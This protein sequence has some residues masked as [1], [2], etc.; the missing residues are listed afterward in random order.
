MPVFYLSPLQRTPTTPNTCLAR[1]SAH[2]SVYST[3]SYLFLYYS[4]YYTCR[5]CC[6][7]RFAVAL[8]MLG[9]NPLVMLCVWLYNL[10]LWSIRFLLVRLLPPLRTG[11]N[12]RL[13]LL[14][15]PPHH[16]DPTH[17]RPLTLL[18]THTTRTHGTQRRTPFFTPAGLLLPTR[19]PATRCPSRCPATQ[20][21]SGK[22]CLLL[23]LAPRDSAAG[24]S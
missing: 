6:N 16:T 8:C 15:R 21:R 5:F 18:P 13:Y 1:H 3:A 7:L 4:F 22:S 10:T 2:V 24:S 19:N 17:L 23:R 11:S 12:S 14:R 9:F 20:W